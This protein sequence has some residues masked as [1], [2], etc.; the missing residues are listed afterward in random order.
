[1]PSNMVGKGP[2]VEISEQQGIIGVEWLG[3]RMDEVDYETSEREL[4]LVQRFE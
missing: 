2:F 4:F 1:M 3:H